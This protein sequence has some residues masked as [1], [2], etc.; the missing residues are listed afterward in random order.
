MNTTPT[1]HKYNNILWVSDI[2]RFLER[3]KEHAAFEDSEKM[4]ALMN[5][6]TFALSF[7]EAFKAIQKPVNGGYDL[8]IMNGSL[9]TQI[10][11]ESKN[12]VR[13]YLQNGAVGELP[14]LPRGCIESGNAMSFYRNML[15]GSDTR[16][17]MLSSNVYN[18]VGGRPE[19]LPF[20]HKPSVTRDDLIRVI[21]FEQSEGEFHG[22]VELLPEE[23]ALIERTHPGDQCIVNANIEYRAID[24]I[25]KDI[26]AGKREVG[27]QKEFIETYLL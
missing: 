17:V 23:L 21:G 18:L 1:A 26:Y 14:R 22:H 12:Q 9:P 4:V 3:V 19:N 11:S 5:R 25:T 27:G 10:F 8:C 6:T 24:E 15:S 20:F 2:P 16:T 7:E 13:E